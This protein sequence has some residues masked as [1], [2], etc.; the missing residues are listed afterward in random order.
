MRL[1]YHG[2]KG[3]ASG[4]YLRRLLFFDVDFLREDFLAVLFF[5]VALFFFAPF[6]GMSAPD[7][8]ASL[9][10]IAMA[11]LGFFTFFPLRPDSSS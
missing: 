2:P 6:F 7:L 9:S 11:C 4:S 5:F 3:I 8:R 10:P 1:I